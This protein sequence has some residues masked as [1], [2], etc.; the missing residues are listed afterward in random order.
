MARVIASS[1]WTLAGKSSI[2]VLSPR[3][4]GKQKSFDQPVG[5]DPTLTLVANSSGA[6]GTAVSR[7]QRVP[8]CPSSGLSAADGNSPPVSL[9]GLGP[10]RDSL[11]GIAESREGCSGE[12]PH[13]AVGD[14][15]ASV[16]SHDLA[17]RVDGKDPGLARRAR[18]SSCRRRRSTRSHA[19]CRRIEVESCDSPGLLIPSA[20]VRRR[21]ARRASCRRLAQQEAMAVAS[22][23]H[24][25]AHDLSMVVDPDA[26]RPQRCR[27]RA[28]R[29]W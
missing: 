10:L 23:V 8:S 21:R 14:A 12:C 24:V 3:L 4:D 16:R 5:V 9:L 13:V 27:G 1:P 2:A 19:G 11:F 7:T 17:F 22:A 20:T 25:V 15:A 6:S 26:H 28:R 29:T 18:R